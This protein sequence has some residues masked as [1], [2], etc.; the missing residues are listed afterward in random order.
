MRW[1]DDVNPG[2]VPGS[3]RI[4]GW[5]IWIE[6]KANSRLTLL[7]LKG[8]RLGGPGAADY[9]AGDKD[10]GWERELLDPV[11]VPGDLR[12]SLLDEELANCQHE[13]GHVLNGR[14]NVLKFQFRQA[15]LLH[16]G[17]VHQSLFCGEKNPDV[18][19]HRNK[20][21]WCKR[22]AGRVW[23]YCRENHWIE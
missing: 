1:L 5:H 6:A 3:F 21:V 20:D 22:S 7:Q 15:E 16:A 18:M 10:L 8:A 11:Q 13:I 9:G 14:R 17:R 19:C 2:F 4:E 12:R 23:I